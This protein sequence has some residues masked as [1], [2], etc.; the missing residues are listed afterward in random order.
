VY[1]NL[2]SSLVNSINLNPQEIGQL[3]VFINTLTDSSFLSNPM[4]APK[5]FVIS[6]SLMHTH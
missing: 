2:D 4:F 6:P 3:I 5:D 1:D